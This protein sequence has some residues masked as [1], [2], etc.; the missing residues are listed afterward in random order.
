MRVFLAGATGAIGRPLVRQL[1]Q[2]GHQV[3]GTTRSPD[4]AGTIRADGGEPVVVDALDRD[5]LMAAVVDAEPEAVVHQLTQIPGEIN[6]RRMARQFEATDRLRTEGTRNLADAAR[7]AGAGRLIAQSIAFAY[8]LDGPDGELKTED[9]PLLGDEAPGSFRRTVKAVA[10]LEKIVVDAGGI[11]LRYGYFYGP[12]TSYAASDGAMAARV[13]KRGF[14]IVGD[15]GG[16]WPFIHVED[17]AAATIAALGHESSDVFNIVD[18][19]PAPLREWLPVYAETVGAKPPLRVPKLAARIAAGKL[20][21]DWA[22]EMRGAS[23]EKAKRELDWELRWPSWR[24]GFVDA[25]G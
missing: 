3:I 2:A 18:D 22:T 8:R 11:V 14:P 25:A 7:A 21:A 19:D 24:Q 5:A 9:D 23:N 4:R 16:V 17:A 1:A 12:G 15:G 20:A 6:P 13:R 10:E